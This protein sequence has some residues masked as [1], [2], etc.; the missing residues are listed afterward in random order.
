MAL[1]GIPK[2]IYEGLRMQRYEEPLLILTSADP[3]IYLFEDS[4]YRWYFFRRAL[5]TT[6]LLELLISDSSFLY[7]RVLP[8][9]YR[10]VISDGTSTEPFR[11]QNQAD[12][13]R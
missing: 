12:R 9:L 4:R 13:N 11:K 6:A 10:P 1:Y 2:A 7:D 3:V 8:S 5:L